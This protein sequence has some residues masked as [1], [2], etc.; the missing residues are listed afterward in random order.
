M[1]ALHL[2]VSAENAVDILRLA[3]IHVEVP[4]SNS[5][6]DDPPPMSTSTSSHFNCNYC[7]RQGRQTVPHSCLLW[8]VSNNTP[9]CALGISGDG[10]V[11]RFAASTNDGRYVFSAFTELEDQISN[12]TPHPLLPDINESLRCFSFSQDA[13]FLATA[14]VEQPWICIWDATED[15]VVLKTSA[16]PSGVV[17]V[18]FSPDGSIL[19]VVGES[20]EVWVLDLFGR[21]YT[22]PPQPDAMCAAVWVDTTTGASMAVIGSRPLSLWK[23]PRTGERS[24]G[25]RFT[26]TLDL[27]DTFRHPLD[28]IGEPLPLVVKFSPDG[29]E[30]AALCVGGSIFLF[31]VASRAV[32]CTLGGSHCTNSIMYS[33]SGDSI[34]GTSDDSLIKVWGRS[35]EVRATLHGPVGISVA[36]AVA[37]PMQSESDNLRILSSASDGIRFWELKRSVSPCNHEIVD[38]STTGA[39]VRTNFDEQILFCFVADDADSLHVWDALR[40]LPLFQIDA[41]SEQYS[42][43]LRDCSVPIVT[44]LSAD[45][46]FGRRGCTMIPGATCPE[47]CTS[48]LWAS[49]YIESDLNPDRSLPDVRTVSPTNFCVASTTG[50]HVYIDSSLSGREIARLENHSHILCLAFSADGNFLVTGAVDSNVRVWDNLGSRDPVCSLQVCFHQKPVV[51]CAVSPND[52]H[53]ATGCTG[54]LIY[55]FHR[56]NGMAVGCLRG[57]TTVVS[58]L[59]FARDETRLVSGSYDRTVRIWHIT[60]DSSHTPATTNTDLSHL[61]SLGSLMYRRTYRPNSNTERQAYVCVRAICHASRVSFVSCLCAPCTWDESDS[62]QG[63]DLGDGCQEPCLVVNTILSCGEGIVYVGPME[64]LGSWKQVCSTYIVSETVDDELI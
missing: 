16:P 26:G 22:A 11:I 25:S 55:V 19:S 51:S 32:R 1:D 21:V 33:P 40:G 39:L 43:C 3:G 60:S 61:G 37:S 42:Y 53:I 29:S 4:K 10:S 18:E 31:D 49:R 45:P 38:A 46:S 2:Y 36:R 47:P 58:S 48:D 15:T 41:P 12:L 27:L 63:T 17:E 24:T 6:L 14:G 13:R 52:T 44:H 64:S 30:I 8:P 9:I 50:S 34:I 57:H 54:G 5:G 35:G 62:Q 23:V 7:P 59:C 28:E 56:D 20:S